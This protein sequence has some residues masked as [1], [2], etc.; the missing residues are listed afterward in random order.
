MAIEPRSNRE[1]SPREQLRRAVLTLAKRRALVLK[2]TILVL[3]AIGVSTLMVTP[4]YKAETSLYVR[5]EQPPVDPLGQEAGRSSRLGAVSPVAVLNSYVETLLSR[6]T[7]EQVVRELQLDAVPP[8]KAL[9]DRIKRSLTGIVSGA[10]SFVTRMMAG[11]VPAAEEDKFRETV[12]DL[13]SSVTAEI[14][15]DTELI[16]V[17]VLYPDRELAREICQKMADTLVARGTIMTRSDAQAAHEAVAA[18]IPAASAR[19]AETDS[20]LSE[21]KRREGI[22]DLTDEQRLHVEQLGNLEMQHAQARAALEEAAARLASAQHSLEDSRQPITLTTVLAE[23][24]QVRE[25]KSD[26]YRQEQQ[27]AA[28]LS[29]HTEE[30]PEVIRLQSQID[31]A[32]QR[33]AREVQ[34]VAAS[35]T[36]GLPPEYSTLA[37]ALVTFESDHIGM[38]AREEAIG[39]LL[40]DFRARLRLLPARDQQLEELARDQRAALANY[41]LLVGRAE[42]LQMAS[43]LSGPPIAI[44]TIDPPRLPKGIFDIGSPPYVLIMILGP[45]LSVLIA[46]TA[47]FVAEYFDDTLGAAE[48]IADGLS[49]PVLVSIP[50]RVADD[51]DDSDVSPGS[52]DG[53]IAGS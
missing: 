1:L 16:L 23:S 41:T 38:T 30:H 3:A 35:E 36:Q 50:H 22:V 7:A 27:L 33:L 34:R 12:D 2:V 47:A 39:V 15:Q 24:P 9:R 20:A 44:A 31:S 29:T 32:H 6:T 42:Q 28:L 48:E 17:T 4:K 5:M 45:I 11:G 49:L 25:I 43:E 53:E 51:Q 13:R 21:F 18:A 52:G 14:D 40:A 19:L 37:Q 46:L 8:S 26:L 10:I